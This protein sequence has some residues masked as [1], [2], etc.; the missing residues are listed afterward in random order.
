MLG[1]PVELSNGIADKKPNLHTKESLGHVWEVL[2]G[3]QNLTALNSCGFL[4]FNRENIIW[5]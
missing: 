2:H 3:E 5:I 1:V 4:V